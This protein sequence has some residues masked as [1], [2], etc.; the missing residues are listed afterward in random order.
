MAIKER[1]RPYEIMIRFGGD[2][3]LV[4]GAHYQTIYE[5]YNGDTVLSAT[6]GEPI[7]LAVADGLE[8]LSLSK[9]LGDSTKSAI[10]ENLQLQTLLEKSKS[11]LRSLI[12]EREDMRQESEKQIQSLQAM[13]SEE[14]AKLK[15]ELLATQQELQKLQELLD[16]NAQIEH[17]LPEGQGTKSA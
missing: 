3:G 13:H 7:S 2:A 6:V 11:D 1:T 10:Q 9:V 15:S 12:A 16:P 5:I 4:V 17:G 14:V 8:G